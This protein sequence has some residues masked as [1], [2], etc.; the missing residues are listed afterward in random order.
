MSCEYLIQFLRLVAVGLVVL[1][2]AGLW[3]ALRPQPE[4]DEH[5]TVFD[6]DRPVI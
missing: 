4:P 5:T 1:A 6:R 3:Y 2:A